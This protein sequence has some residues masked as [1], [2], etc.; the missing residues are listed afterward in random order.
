M[1]QHSIKVAS[2]NINS[3][4]ARVE[5]VEQF[6]IDYA[7]D[8]LCLQ[9]T[10]VVNGTF[11]EGLFR[12]HGYKY[13]MTTG[14]TGKPMARLAISARDSTMAC[15]SRMSISRPAAMSPTARSIPNSARNSIS[16]SG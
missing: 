4:R 12:K 6:L 2:W 3:V 8:V 9:E 7:P 5:I 16:S 11:P 14:S 10:K 13:Q 1:S 15:A